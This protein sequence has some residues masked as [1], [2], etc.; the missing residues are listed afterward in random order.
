MVLGSLTVALRAAD[1]LA[2]LR[3]GVD[4]VGIDGIVPGAAPAAVALEVDRL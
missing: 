4:R 2:V 1:H 3:E